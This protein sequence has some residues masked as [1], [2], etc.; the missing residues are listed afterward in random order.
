MFNTLSE[1]L[2]IHL[3][4]YLQPS[5]LDSYTSLS[6]LHFEIKTHCW[7]NAGSTWF[8]L[9][10]DS[11]TRQQVWQQ[12]SHQFKISASDKRNNVI[13]MNNSSQYWTPRSTCT[14][15]IFGTVAMC[16]SV[17]WF[18]IQMSKVVAVTGTYSAFLRLKHS[19][20]GSTFNLS[21]STTDTDVPTSFATVTHT[22]TRGAVGRW[23]NV[24]IGDITIQTT[25][26]TVTG[27]MW[28]HESSWV[29]NLSVDHLFLVEQQNESPLQQG[30]QKKCELM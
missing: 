5:T 19:S 22:P 26:T 7:L 6:K 3:S 9:K 12:W 21:A 4:F 2:L 15:S 16:K 13:I 8:S 30:E 17:C 27:R 14:E 20:R 1:D 28:K 25:T 23:I 18:D 29:S 11:S 24:Y 10:P